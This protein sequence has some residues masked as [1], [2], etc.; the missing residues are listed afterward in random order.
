MRAAIAPRSRLSILTTKGR[1]MDRYHRVHNGRATR[2][3]SGRKGAGTRETQINVQL[4]KAR[5]LA[6]P[7]RYRYPDGT[8]VM[9]AIFMAWPDVARALAHAGVVARMARAGRKTRAREH[10]RG[11]MADIVRATL[12]QPLHAHAARVVRSAHARALAV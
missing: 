10:A 8:P 2:R 12:A 3:H 5:A 9:W 4:R 6:E 11:R 7:V 1:M